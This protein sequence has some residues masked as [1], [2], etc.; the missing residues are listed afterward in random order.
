[1]KHLSIHADNNSVSLEKICCLFYL[2]MMKW[3]EKSILLIYTSSMLS[4]KIEREKNTERIKILSINHNNTSRLSFLL[5]FFSLSIFTFSTF[6]LH[7]IAREFVDWTSF[8]KF[9]LP[10]IYIYI[11]RLNT[12][13]ICVKRKTQEKKKVF[14]EKVE[15]S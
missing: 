12:F 1:M 10:L 2:C 13:C 3:W 5:I 9:I 11:Y 15:R 7:S 8:P 4:H 14:V 6:L